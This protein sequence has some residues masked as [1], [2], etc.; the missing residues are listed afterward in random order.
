MSAPAEQ[1]VEA[2]ERALSILEAF[3]DNEPSLSLAAIAR[4]TG[5]NPSTILR[6]S[7]SLMRFGYLRRL[8]DGRYS[9]GP[10]P[11]QLGTLYRNSGQGPINV[12]VPAVNRGALPRDGWVMPPS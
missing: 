7:A 3:V 10:A 11:L 5:F 9:L 1:R 12:L 4:H 2:V 6:L 8:S